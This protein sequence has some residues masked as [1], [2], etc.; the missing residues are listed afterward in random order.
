MTFVI[1]SKKDVITFVGIAEHECLDI[2]NT[3][4]HED[5]FKHQGNEVKEERTV[6][7]PVE[8]EELEDV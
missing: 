4:D 6:Y 3:S 5:E 2:I 7:T 1:C 8:Y